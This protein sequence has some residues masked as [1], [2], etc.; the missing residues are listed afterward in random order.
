MESDIV[1]FLNP[2]LLFLKKESI[3]IA[4]KSVPKDN[5]YLESVKRFNSWVYN[6]SGLTI[7]LDLKG[8]NTKNLPIQFEAAHA[9]RVFRKDT[10]LNKGDMSI[11]N[12]MLYVLDEEECVDIDTIE[13]Y[14]F[15]RWKYETSN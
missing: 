14:N 8:M 12:P 9:F 6:E 3:E 5:P 2:C 15:A 1:M 11:V 13:D 4:I 10:F 7:D